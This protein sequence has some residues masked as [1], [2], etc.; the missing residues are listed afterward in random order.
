M[1]RFVLA[2]YDSSPDYINHFLTALKGTGNLPFEITGFTSPSALGKFVSGAVVNILLLS[3][4]GEEAEE[5]EIN[6]ILCHENIKKAVYLGEQPEKKNDTG[7]I[8]KYQ[9]IHGIAADLLRIWNACGCETSGQSIQ[10]EIYGVYSLENPDD[11]IC[12]SLDLARSL[13]RT[14]RVLYIETERFSGLKDQEG[15]EASGNLS[16]I[17]YLY[18]TNPAKLGQT[19]PGIITHLY[20]VDIITGS[21]APEDFDET[22]PTTWPDI[23]QTLAS[24]G[25]YETLVVGI[26]DSFRNIELIFSLCCSVYLLVPPEC[27]NRGNTFSGSL[28]SQRMKEFNLFFE[29]NERSDILK[30]IIPID[31][32]QAAGFRTAGMA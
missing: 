30:K 7:Y 21:N 26:S 17:I 25:G 8:C 23:F 16:D 4:S 6:K 1:S 10:A 29:G 5:T 32:N 13:S 14:G 20:G 28:S 15:N 11:R 31:M 2:V 9:S 24:E 3:L 27:E 12:L 19:L 18:K 22:E